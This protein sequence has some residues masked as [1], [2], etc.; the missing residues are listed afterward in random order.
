MGVL[1]ERKLIARE[2]RNS[3]ITAYYGPTEKLREDLDV[4]DIRQ[5]IRTFSQ[6][7][8]DEVTVALDLLSTIKDIVVVVHGAIGCCAAMIGYQYRNNRQL[9]TKE[10][11]NNSFSWYS[12]NLNERDTI[13]GGDEKL[14]T[15]VEQ[16][17]HDHKPGAIF[18]VGTSVVAINN[19]DM[20]SIILELQEELEIPII[21]INTDGFKSKAGINGSDIVLHGIGKYLIS[22]PQNETKQK[23]IANQEDTITQQNIVEE[24]YHKVQQKVTAQENIQINIISTSLNHQTKKELHHV[25]D[26]LELGANIIPRYATIDEIQTANKSVASIALNNEEAEVLLQG[27]EDRGIPSIKAQAPIGT[28]AI[29]KWFN[30]LG[31]HLG[32]REQV[33]AFIQEEEKKVQS[34]IAKQP[35][36]GERVYIDLPASLAASTVEL[37]EELGGEVVGITIPFV[38]EG[39]KENLRSWKK[40]IYVQVGDSQLFELPNIFAKNKVTYYI[41]EQAK[42]GFVVKQGLIPI[43]IGN[44]NIFFYQGIK[45]FIECFHR[46]KRS[47]SYTRHISNDS[48]KLYSD[49]WTKKSTNWY[50]K[51]EVK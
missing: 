32:I 23:D 28:K 36:K 12:T 43:P 50:I 17:Y 30:K 48:E 25:F 33:E 27:L 10:T 24:Q 18:V 4:T 46:A 35:L 31:K 5:R 51:Q 41:S 11:E 9:S 29:S 49:S 38:D 44:K 26:K 7:T 16:A 45:N 2:K 21:L 42:G 39:N 3:T 22:N 6:T 47:V 20:T 37:V 15:V 40:E 1:E 14:R 34:Y 13:M 8:S 19:D